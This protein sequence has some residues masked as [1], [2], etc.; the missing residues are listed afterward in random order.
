[1]QGTLAGREGHDL[2]NKW[3]NLAEE[4]ASIWKQLNFNY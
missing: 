2:A 1:M 3:V 4:A